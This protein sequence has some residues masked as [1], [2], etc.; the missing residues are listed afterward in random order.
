[1]CAVFPVVAIIITSTILPES[2]IWLRDRGR[3]DEAYDILKRFRGIPATSEIPEDLKAE[4]QLRPQRK[5]QNY[6]KHLLK[7]SS[8]VPFTIMLIYFIF[9]QFSGLFVIVYYAVNITKDAGVKIDAYLGAILIG[10]TRLLASVLVASIS[11]RFG[12]RLPSIISGS[13]MTFFMG[14][15]SIYLYLLSRGYSIPD[16]GVIPVICISMYIFTSTLGFLVVP[17][18]MIGEIFPARVKDT[19]TGA[20]TCLAY[21]VSFITVKTYPDMLVIFGKHGVFMFY[22][23]VSL[24]GTIFVLM[25]LPETKGKTLREIEEIYCKKKQDSE[26]PLSN[27]KMIPMKDVTVLS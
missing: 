1:M 19:L 15:L 2:P 14:T 16:G 22:A 17:F 21:I 27:E 20:T 7:R 9:Q 13:G 24:L 3:M 5:K 4:I 26:D 11:K 6:M 23:L 25:F 10:F 18:A 8:V 12:R